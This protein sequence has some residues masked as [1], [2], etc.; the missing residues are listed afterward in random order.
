[1][2]HVSSRCCEPLR[3]GTMETSP[4]SLSL[5]LIASAIG[6]GLMQDSSY[7]HCL[8]RRSKNN[9]QCTLRSLKQ[10]NFIIV[11]FELFPVY[12]YWRHAHSRLV[13][14][15]RLSG[16]M[17]RTPPQD[18]PSSSFNWQRKRPTLE[19]LDDFL[20][21]IVLVLGS[22]LH[23]NIGRGFMQDSAF[24][25]RYGQFGQMQL[26]IRSACT[27]TILPPQSVREALLWIALNSFSNDANL[28][29]I[30]PSS[31][32]NHSSSSILCNHSLWH[33]SLEELSLHNA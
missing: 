3:Q 21:A 24:N 27:C 23:L 12:Q 1:M 2:I 26:I 17:E 29:L 9:S 33:V 25:D 16:A 30:N 22:C 6:R 28:T 4:L 32:S 19:S 11:C 20:T 5:S 13:S 15:N 8:D 31:L 10:V 7:D 14:W 18:S